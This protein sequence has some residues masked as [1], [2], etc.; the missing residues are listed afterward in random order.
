[1]LQALVEAR[2]RADLL[3]GRLVH[4]DRRDRGKGEPGA[5][6][7]AT[8][9]LPV[10]AF[11]NDPD[12]AYVEWSGGYLTR[13]TAI[14]TLAGETEDEQEWFRHYRVNLR[15]G[16]LEAGFDG[17]AENPYDIAPLGDGSWLTTD[18]SGHPIRWA[19]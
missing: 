17:H 10:E 3:S 9:E 5:Q 8:L 13:D 15:S 11:G 19:Q 18:P 7:D 4:D 1:M 6:A 12:E 16:Q 2:D 14:V